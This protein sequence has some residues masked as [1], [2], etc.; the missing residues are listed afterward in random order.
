[1]T[2]KALIYPCSRIL[3]TTFIAYFCY[4]SI[5]KRSKDDEGSQELLKIGL[6]LVGLAF[7]Y[8]L[9]RNYQDRYAAI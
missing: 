4:S 8:V 1:M 6:F 7:L 3:L 2:Y 5:S 9:F